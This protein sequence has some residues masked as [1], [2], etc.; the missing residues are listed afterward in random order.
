M[1]VHAHIHT[2]NLNQ[3]RE[4]P[5]AAPGLT[6]TLACCQP[7][8]HSPLTI[9]RSPVLDTATTAYNTPVHAAFQVLFGLLPATVAVVPTGLQAL[10]VRRHERPAFPWR[11]T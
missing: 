8:L 6:I 9:Y 11:H 7:T 2:D 4:P 10:H 1:Y 3:L 5:A